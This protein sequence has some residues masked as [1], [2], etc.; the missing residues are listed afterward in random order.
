MRVG[1]NLN[2]H[3]LTAEGAAPKG[4]VKLGGRAWSLRLE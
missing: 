1:L 2:P 3:P 4:C